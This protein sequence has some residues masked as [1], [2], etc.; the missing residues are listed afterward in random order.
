M[1]PCPFRAA[2]VHFSLRLLLLMFL[3]LPFGQVLAIDAIV[4]AASGAVSALRAAADG[5]PLERAL[6]AADEVNAGD[7][8]R[9]RQ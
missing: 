3:S 5:R 6:R 1:R 2:R 4:L 7:C 8:N 9:D